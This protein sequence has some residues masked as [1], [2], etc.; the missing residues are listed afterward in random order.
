MTERETNGR[1]KKK[2]LTCEDFHKWVTNHFAA[3]EKKVA[4]NTG[5]LAVIIVLV[6]AILVKVYFG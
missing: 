6:I 5:A 2:Y 3:L 1:W 4:T